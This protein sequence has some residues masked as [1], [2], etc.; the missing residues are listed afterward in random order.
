MDILAQHETNKKSLVASL[1]DMMKVKRERSFVLNQSKAFKTDSDQIP[2]NHPGKI[3]VGGRVNHAFSKSSTNSA[4]NGDTKPSVIIRPG[5]ERKKDFKK[6]EGAQAKT[7]ALRK[8]AK[9]S[10]RGALIPK[11][12]I[13][14]EMK[15]DGMDALIQRGAKRRTNK[16]KQKRDAAVRD[17]V[18]K[19]IS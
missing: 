4:S 16:K 5:S 6:K 2:H 9:R 8:S 19:Q 12:R 13:D 10:S 17:F 15:L 18:M 1:I 3:S 7:K 14:V 11:R